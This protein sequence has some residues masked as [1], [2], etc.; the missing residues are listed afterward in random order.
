MVEREREPSYAVRGLNMEESMTEKIEL[1]VSRPVL[2]AAT[3]TIGTSREALRSWLVENGIHV[4]SY[5]DQHVWEIVHKL[6]GDLRRMVR[7]AGYFKFACKLHN[8][9][10]CPVCACPTCHAPSG[11]SCGTRR[12]RDYNDRGPS[13]PRKRDGIR[14]VGIEAEVMVRS[15][16]LQKLLES[17]PY[18]HYDGSLGGGGAEAKLV[19]YADRLH[20]LAEI[21]KLIFETDGVGTA[22][23][24]GLHVHV[25]RDPDADPLTGIVNRW[26]DSQDRIYKAFPSRR[27]NHYCK[28]VDTGLRDR[29]VNSLSDYLS[30]HY[31]ALSLSRKHPTY[32]IRVHGGSS[33]WAVVGCWADWCAKLVEREPSLVGEQYLK[34]R[35]ASQARRGDLR[36]YPWAWRRVVER[37]GKRV[38]V[39]KA[40]EDVAKGVFGKFADPV[41]L[42][43]AAKHAKVSIWR[44]EAEEKA[45]RDA[46]DIPPF[47]DPNAPPA[48]PVAEPVAE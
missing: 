47:A 2:V 44:D 3:T 5:D 18:C 35:E 14:R 32:E 36:P 37:H 28:A 43:D 27:N 42:L 1:P 30:D 12:I 48:P 6:R 41:T 24:C 34:A 33:S 7:D 10:D 9:L 22:D 11:C 15:S 20:E 16:N 8:R 13:L 19:G 17:Y 38:G 23:C 45:A 25:E 31:S 26:L 40:L 39:R 29:S 21:S 46:G 4:R